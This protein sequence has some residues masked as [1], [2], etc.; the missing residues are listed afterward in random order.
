MTFEKIKASDRIFVSGQ[1]GMVGSAI[2]RKLEKYGFG[3]QKL[4][5]SLLTADKIEL[6]LTDPYAVEK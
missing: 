1:R 4:G 6:D 3:D 5:G 2:F